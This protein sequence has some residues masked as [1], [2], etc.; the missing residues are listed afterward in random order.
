[1]FVFGTHFFHFGN[2]WYKTAKIQNK[3]A[4]RAHIFN[5]NNISLLLL[6]TKLMTK[7]PWPRLGCERFLVKEERNITT[8]AHNVGKQCKTGIKAYRKTREGGQKR[9]N[10]LKRGTLTPY[11][12][13]L[14]SI[15]VVYYFL[16][17]FVCYRLF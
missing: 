1:M 15:S 10:Q 3:W 7:I 12:K 6:M 8:I 11:I 4:P 13:Y 2:I 16:Y 14:V 5:Y 17:Y 9:V